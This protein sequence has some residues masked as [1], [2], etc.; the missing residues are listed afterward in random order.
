M[1]KEETVNIY[2]GK[3]IDVKDDKFIFRVKIAIPGYTDKLSVDDLPFYFPF[4]GVNYLPLVN[5]VVPVLIFDNVFTNGFYGRK[6]DCLDR[7]LDEND[8]ENYL[9]IYKR[10]VND[11]NV[12][13]SYVPSLGIQIINDKSNIN[14]KEEKISIFTDIDKLSIILNQENNVISIGDQNS[15]QK[16]LLGENVIDYLKN[17]QLDFSKKILSELTNFVTGIQTAASSN[18]Y[19]A[20]LLAPCLKSITSL[21][22]MLTHKAY[23]FNFSDLESKNVKN[24]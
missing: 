2:F 23:F 1:K 16:S 8:Y 18:P 12:E 15:L 24:S 5:D 9:E 20:N 6:I 21:Q 11:K 10:L 7:N 4:Y 17:V 3:V 14:L 13:L 19:T 22:N